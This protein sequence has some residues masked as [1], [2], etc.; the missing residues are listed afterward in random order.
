MEKKETVK[1]NVFNT[2][3]FYTNSLADKT[4]VF[5]CLIYIYI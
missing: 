4:N 3:T 1:E 2:G 5:I